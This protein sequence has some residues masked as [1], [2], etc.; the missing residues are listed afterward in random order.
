[1][2]SHVWRF[3]GLRLLLQLESVQRKLAGA[4]LSDAEMYRRLSEWLYDIERRR[5]LWPQLLDCAQE[6]ERT[7]VRLS[8]SARM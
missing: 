3:Q 7:R 8:K 6:I 2:R 1:M 5:L 4:K